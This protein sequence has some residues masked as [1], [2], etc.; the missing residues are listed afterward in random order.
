MQVKGTL[1]AVGCLA[2]L[3]GCGSDSKKKEACPEGTKA[4]AEIACDCGK[5]GKVGKQT[6][7]KDMTLTDCACPDDG[8]GTDGGAGSGGSTSSG[9]GGKGST[10]GMTTG[11]G[12]K[13]GGSMSSGTGGKSGGG[14]DEDGGTTTP[15]TDGGSSGGNVVPLPK[16]GNQLASCATGVDCNM[17]LDCYNPQGPAEGFCTKAGCMSDDDCKGLAGGTYTCA[18]QSGLCVISCMGTD[19]KSCPDQ[20][21]CVQTGTT[22]G[23]G[24]PGGPGGGG[25][26]TPVYHCTYPEGAGV[27]KQPLWGKCTSFTSADC[28]TDLVCSGIGFT[29]MGGTTPGYCSEMCE[30]ADDC[31]K[32]KTG[33]IDPTC[34]PSGFGGGGPM[35]GGGMQTMHCALDCAM[36]TDGCP[37]GM[38]C[39]MNPGFMG[40]GAS[41]RCGYEN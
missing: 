18:M 25:G 24:G 36:N 17:G 7:Q 37:D 39:I 16:D 32:P 41:S 5:L 8:S 40:M 20:M 3:A 31:T 34:V 33:A 28:D 13:S 2:L 29:M 10:G 14:S 30:S 4:G 26:G 1:I 23:G 21:T 27:A 9:S 38:T 22:G 11:S 12:G 15:P 19:D 35:M 6:C